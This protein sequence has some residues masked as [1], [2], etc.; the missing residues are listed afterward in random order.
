MKK[1]SVA[2]VASAL[3]LVA[4]GASGKIKLKSETDPACKPPKPYAF[5]LDTQSEVVCV[6]QKTFDK[7][8]NGDQYP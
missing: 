7:Y 3:V 4:C 8:S 5:H 2:V 6:D 1:M